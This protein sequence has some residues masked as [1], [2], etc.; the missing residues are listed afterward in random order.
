MWLLKP[1]LG[2]CL[3]ILDAHFLE[4]EG[5]FSLEITQK[6]FSWELH[7]GVHLGMYQLK[8]VTERHYHL[9]NVLL[10][11]RPLYKFHVKNTFLF[12]GPLQTLSTKTTPSIQKDE[13]NPVWVCRSET[14]GPVVL[15]LTLLGYWST[16]VTTDAAHCDDLSTFQCLWLGLWSVSF[17]WRLLEPWECLV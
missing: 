8:G 16:W 13:T 3:Q 1:S 2:N 12:L 17:L 5:K 15:P 6:G 10:L 9:L 7:P 4:L 14:W 11:A